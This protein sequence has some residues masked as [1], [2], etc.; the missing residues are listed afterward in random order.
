MKK[1]KNSK[2]EMIIR[3]IQFWKQ[4]N[5]LPEQYCDYLLALYTGGTEIDEKKPVISRRKNMFKDLLI[6]ICALVISLFVIYFTELSIVLQTAILTGFV[7]LLI[8][9]GIYYTKKQLS[10]MLLYTVAGCIFLLASV[11]I[12]GMVFNGSSLALYFTLF[13]NCFIWVGAGLKWKLNYFSIA[14]S[15]GAM[16]VFI[17]IL[18]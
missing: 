14:G 4:T 15:I 5:L 12:S 7:G 13:L 1:I 11:D 10:P 17:Y 6:S 16:F 2:T 9:V 8:G 18:L 3:E